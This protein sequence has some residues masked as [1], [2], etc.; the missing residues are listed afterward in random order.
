MKLIRLYYSKLGNKGI[1]LKE[2]WWCRIEFPKTQLRINATF[3]PHMYSFQEG[4]AS[5]MIPRIF[6]I[7]LVQCSE[8]RILELEPGNNLKRR[9]FR[10]HHRT[11]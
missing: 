5:K 1:T 8:E 9:I 10:V 7:S 4:R 6:V 2:I 3:R 11:V